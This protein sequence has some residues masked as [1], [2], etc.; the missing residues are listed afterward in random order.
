MKG[1]DLALPFGTENAQGTRMLS[2]NANPSSQLHKVW[3]VI[4]RFLPLIQ[5]T[6]S[7]NSLARSYLEL[8]EE[9]NYP[10]DFPPGWC[11]EEAALHVVVSEPGFK[12]WDF[13]WGGGGVE[14]APR[15]HPHPA[16]TV[17][18]RSGLFATMSGIPP[19]AAYCL[20]GGCSGT[21]AHPCTSW[22]P[23]THPP[24]A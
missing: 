20:L 5:W 22:G 4:R 24:P 18:L 12:G 1:T 17:S 10:G 2:K 8:S 3:P 14:Q 19:T 15:C 6:H 21:G 7:R 13:L 11:E 9:L 23:E 16:S